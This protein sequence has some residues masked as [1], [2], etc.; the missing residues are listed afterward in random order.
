[1]RFVTGDKTGN[2]ANTLLVIAC[3]DVHPALKPIQV[4]SIR[5]NVTRRGKI[6]QRRGPGFMTPVQLSPSNK[7]ISRGGRDRFDVCRH[8]LDL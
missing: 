8:L 4:P 1:M 7:E 6:S 3:L 5:L 2:Q